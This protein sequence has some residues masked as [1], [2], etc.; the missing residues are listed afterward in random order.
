MFYPFS[1]NFLST[2]L[3]GGIKGNNNIW[4][5]RK[6][7]QQNYFPRTITRKFL[8]HKLGGNQQENKELGKK[9]VYSNRGE[10]THREL[11]TDHNVRD[12]PTVKIQPLDPL[13]L[14]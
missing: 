2:K 13:I 6:R 14:Q 10:H 4:N 12:H 3:N 5:T 7:K 11:N 1:G 9:K 8:G